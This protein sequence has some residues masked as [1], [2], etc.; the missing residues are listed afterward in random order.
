MAGG[1]RVFLMAF[2]LVVAAAWPA[3]ALD[4]GATATPRA[5]AA[6]K[7][8]A[9]VIGNGAYRHAPPLPNP[10]NDARDM[11]GLLEGLGFETVFGVNLDRA[12]MEDRI[13]AFADRS[14]NAA[15]TLFYYAGHGMQV[16]GRNYLIPV[17]AALSTASALQF[18]TVEADTVLRFMVGGDR[19]AIALLDAC[20][21]NPLSRSF[22]ATRSAGASRGLAL[23]ATGGGI[24]IGFATAP[25]E[26]AADGEGRNSPFA[27]A[28]LRHLGA[29]DTEISRTMRRVMADV[30]ASTRERQRP[31]IHSDIAVDFYLNPD[32]AA[33]GDAPVVAQ[34]PAQPDEPA[35]E[36]LAAL[37]PDP[38]PGRA[39]GPVGEAAAPRIVSVFENETFELCGFGG[40]KA[41]MIAGRVGLAS[42]DRGVPGRSFRGYEKALPLDMPV[43]L[44]K[45]CTVTASL[46]ARGGV[47][48]ITLSVAEGR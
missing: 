42:L 33:A 3:A 43:E 24:M 39:T 41:S 5:L 1:I 38:K 22:V 20:R 48:R 2:A 23:P 6:G 31:W 11:A 18:E 28:L 26:T 40:F 16:D 29:P 30:S 36:Q 19:I 27:A 4:R 17:D 10:A 12:G 34:R 35:S 21:D 7:R 9:L 47:S 15:V 46:A 45:D 32:P 13:R 14:A 8:V 44:W 37:A 25:G